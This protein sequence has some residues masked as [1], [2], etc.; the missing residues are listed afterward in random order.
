MV[1]AG[2]WESEGMGLKG[3]LGGGGG[4][5]RVVGKRETG[6]GVG[7]RKEGRR[8]GSLVCIGAPVEGGAGVT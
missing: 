6:R 2:V 4:L 7:G 8:L 3:Q 5:P 1:G